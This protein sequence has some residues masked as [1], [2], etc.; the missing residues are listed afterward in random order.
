VGAALQSDEIRLLDIVLNLG[1]VSVW[2]LFGFRRSQNRFFTKE[3]VEE[4]LNTLRNRQ[5]ISIHQDEYQRESVSINPTRQIEVNAL[6]KEYI[7]SEGVTRDKLI[8][9]AQD[10]SET[11]PK[12]LALTTREGGKSRVSFS[13]YQTDAT[14]IAL[15][16][17][18]ATLGIVLENRWDSKKHSYQTFYLRRFPFDAVASFEAF[19][20]SKINFDAIRSPEEWI[21]TAT[22]IFSEEPLRIGDFAFNLPEATF[23]GVRE[24]IF[25]LEKRGLLA[26]QG[27]YLKS[28][29]GVKKLAQGYFIAERTQWFKDFML[30]RAKR[31]IGELTSNLY[32]VGL[33]KR[34]VVY[35][36]GSSLATPFLR[37]S[38]S[39]IPSIS[40]EDLVEAAKLGLILLTD[41]EVL[42]AV[43][44]VNE[45]ESIFKTALSEEAFI[46]VHAKNLI[47]TN[48]AW[49]R[50]FEE[51][52]T[53]YLKIQDEYANEKTLEI[54]QSY[55]APKLEIRILSSIKGPDDL[56]VDEVKEKVKLLES[57]GNK[58][59]LRF[60]GYIGNGEAPFHQRYVI[61]KESCFFLSQTIKD[62]GKTK[63]ASI[64]ELAK[65]RKA[66]IETAFDYWYGLPESMLTEKGLQRW[67]YG[68]WLNKKSG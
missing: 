20:L 26:R 33:V 49:K 48:M 34:L 56:S 57:R 45:L 46:V 40:K 38:R 64:I 55:L 54:L 12:L 17:K 13:D 31:N 68:E 32:Y 39:Q 63:E 50:L 24:V 53:G 30:S 51:K 7:E 28:D 14:A 5:L 8:E 21:V 10:N 36:S 2:E 29:T 41:N 9:V 27:E 6:V 60:V 16:S 62:V 61:S 35:H 52:C 59:D 18:L 66:Q 47:E 25:N 3:R 11:V 37:V 58:V 65:D 19:I 15:C 22:V 43:D 1:N 67:S 42:I 44:V 4:I 23:N